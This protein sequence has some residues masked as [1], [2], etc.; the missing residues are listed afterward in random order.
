ML[1]AAILKTVLEEV[2]HPIIITDAIGNYV[3]YNRSAQKALD[4]KDYMERQETL[5]ALVV[6]KRTGEIYEP[7]EYPSMKALRGIFTKNERMVIEKVNTG[8]VVY[9]DVDAFPIFNENRDI[10]LGAVVSFNDVTMNIMVVRVLDE[11]NAKVS[12][13]MT[14]LTNSFWSPDIL[15]N[16]AF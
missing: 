6:K 3:L 9:L 12:H 4:F 10:V 5:S 7:D 1:N 15:P 8:K 11:V 13:M 16:I 2:Q 14:L